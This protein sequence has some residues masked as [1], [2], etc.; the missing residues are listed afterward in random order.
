MGYKC[1]MQKP[2][3]YANQ[4]YGTATIGE[5]ACGPA[6]VCNALYAAGIADVGVPD[7]CKRAVAAG[8]RIAHQGTQMTTLLNAVRNVY[9]FTYTTTNRNAELVEHL[10]R[11][12][13]AILW[14]G[15]SYPYFTSSGHYTA[16]V[17]IKPD[18]KTIIV[19]DS[20]YYS[21]KWNYRVNGAPRSCVIKP[22]YSSYTTGIV[23]ADISVIGKSTSGKPVSYFLITPTTQDN[24]KTQPE[25]VQ[26]VK[27]IV[28]NLEMRVNGSTQNISAVNVDGHN[29]VRL[30]QLPKLLPVTVG[31]DGIPIVDTAQINV[32]VDGST[33]QLPGGIIA[34]G[35]S[36]AYIADLA[37]MLDYDAEWD[38]KNH[39]VVLTK[40]ADT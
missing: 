28:K 26:E 8:A 21:G 35:K 38:G 13:P 30:D 2:A 5:S 39:A 20:L 34:P 19:A 6:A 32:V 17:G 3:S 29:Y 12:Y 31:Y 16:A 22:Y 18:S 23:T 40:R 25:A 27:Y 36:L 24:K 9:G 11:G 15:S 37:S 10:K 7:M 4:M 33:M 1:K 14:N